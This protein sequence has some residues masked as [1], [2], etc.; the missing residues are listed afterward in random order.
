MRNTATV[1]NLSYRVLIIVFL[2]EDSLTSVISKVSVNMVFHQSKHISFNRLRNALQTTFF[3]SEIIECLV[4]AGNYIL[5][6]FG[7]RMFPLT[8]PEILKKKQRNYCRILI[9]FFAINAVF[10]KSQN[11]EI[12]IVKPVNHLR[13]CVIRI[14]VCGVCMKIGFIVI[15]L[16]CDQLFNIIIRADNFKNSLVFSRHNILRKIDLIYYNTIKIIMSIITPVEVVVYTNY[17]MAPAHVQLFIFYY[18]FLTHVNGSMYSFSDMLKK[19]K[20]TA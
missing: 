19:Q 20:G 15:F 11:I 17:I 3:S 8:V 13:H 9:P 6:L 2:T 4:F 10:S 18:S 16:I 14:T 1:F 12:V 7:C 5:I